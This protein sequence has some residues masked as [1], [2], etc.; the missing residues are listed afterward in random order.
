MVYSFNQA[1]FRTE[2]FKMF[3]VLDSSSFSFI[4]EQVSYV[5]LSEK[6]DYL[7]N[8]KSEIRIVRD[9][10]AG[11]CLQVIKIMHH[12]DNG[13]FDWLIS[14]QQSVNPS[15]GAISILPGKYKDLRLSIL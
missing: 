12:H 11:H 14:G 9:V 15:R 5:T 13:G 3:S 8:C 4:F 10:V 6:M 7:F 2:N 1:V